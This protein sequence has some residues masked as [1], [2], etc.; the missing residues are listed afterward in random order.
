MVPVC[1]G[2]PIFVGHFQ[3]FPEWGIINHIRLLLFS[4]NLRIEDILILEYLRNS[5]YTKRS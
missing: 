3:R 2:V 1:Q 5:E 4:V